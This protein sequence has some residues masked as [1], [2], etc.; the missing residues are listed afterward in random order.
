M[1]EQTQVETATS[2]Q[3][4]ETMD[5]VMR[6]FPVETAAES[7][8]AQPKK[9]DINPP[10]MDIPDPS[11][12]PDGFKKTMQEFQ[13][14]DWEVKQALNRVSEQLNGMEQR[15]QRQV[16]EEDISATVEKIQEEIP[17][18]K[19]KDRVVKGYLGAV[20]NEDPRIAR[21]WE[22]RKQNPAA[23]DKTLSVITKQIS[24]DFDFVA[25]P[26]L[27]ENVRA[28]KASRDQMATTR[29]D[30]PDEKWSKASPGEF[31]LM[32]DRLINN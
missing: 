19:G 10:K 29:A 11:Y 7:F 20:A 4:A 6:Q 12:D 3:P 27:A 16:E 15:T 2:E 30:S 32:W 24:R 28:A 31:E 26:Q 14:N 18:L 9:E 22:N 1:A 13:T 8:T 25:D 23:W 17:I 5:D 21:V